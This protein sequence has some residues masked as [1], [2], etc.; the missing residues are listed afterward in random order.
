MLKVCSMSVAELTTVK[1]V[2]LRNARLPPTG[3]TM[4][5]LPTAN[6]VTGFGAMVK[7]RGALWA[8]P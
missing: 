2:P 8:F 7:V 5:Q 6:V 1:L 4:V 3:H